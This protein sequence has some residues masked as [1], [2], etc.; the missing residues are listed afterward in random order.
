MA[1]TSGDAVLTP[2]ELA[3]TA[4]VTVNTVRWWRHVGLGPKYIKLSE[5][6]IRYRVED[7]DAWL[8]TLYAESK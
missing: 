2:R 7:V 4:K 5:R 3:N 6:V 8:D 1:A